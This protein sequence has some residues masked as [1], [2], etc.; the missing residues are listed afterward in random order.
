MNSPLVAFALFFLSLLGVA[1]A[2]PIHE[3]VSAWSPADPV[4]TIINNSAKD[5]VFDVETD[6]LAGPSAFKSC[7]QCITVGAK[8]TIT[9]HPGAGFNGALT[10]NHHAG[11]RHEI[12]FNQIPGGTWYDVDMENGMSDETLGPSD[13]HMRTRNGGASLAG[14]SNTLAK[15]NAAW[16]SK[17]DPNTKQALLHSGFFQGT[18][19]R[20]TH[21]RMQNGAPEL[22]VHWLQVTAG[23]N[24]YV[25]PGS[26]PGVPATPASKVADSKSWDIATNKMTITL[27]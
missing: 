26:V 2:R 11:S 3:G 1:T 25:H 6:S 24:A 17:T 5:N 16:K 20:L 8:Q 21:V 27:Y 4:I 7:S 15:A 19:E 13:V 18:E 9:F 10:R 22:V 14:E 12:N 23:F